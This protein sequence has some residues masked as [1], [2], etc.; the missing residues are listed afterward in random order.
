MSHGDGSL[1]FWLEQYVTDGVGHFARTT[2]FIRI[3]SRVRG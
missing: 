2:F 3:N 1:I